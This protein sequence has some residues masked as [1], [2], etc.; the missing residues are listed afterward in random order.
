MVIVGF[1]IRNN[2]CTSETFSQ[3]LVP[4]LDSRNYL[5]VYIRK[6]ALADRPS[7]EYSNNGIKAAQTGGGFSVL[8]LLYLSILYTTHFFGR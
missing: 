4:K 8:H 1:V 7:L 2:V 5:A 6:V 3:D